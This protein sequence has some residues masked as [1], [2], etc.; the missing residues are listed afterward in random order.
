LKPI[1]G[2][3]W[4]AH[5]IF[6]QPVWIQAAGSV[7]FVW[8]DAL[9]SAKFNKSVRFIP[10]KGHCEKIEQLSNIPACGKNH[11][12]PNSRRF[13]WIPLHW[14]WILWENQVT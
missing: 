9:L 6:L 7:S 13:L 5:A 11:A 3:N 14:A 2:V 4:P 10:N 12:P 1:E 8:D